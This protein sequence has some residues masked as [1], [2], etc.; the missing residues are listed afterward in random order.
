MKL[1]H[2]NKGNSYISP[3]RQQGPKP[4]QIP[5]KSILKWICGIALVLFLFLGIGIGCFQ[6]YH[7]ATTA[8]CFAIKDVSV[9]G[10]SQLSEQDILS[11]SGLHP[12]VNC[13]TVSIYD[14]ERN[15]Y[16]NPWVASVSVQR[17]LPSSFE[18][19]VT[20]HKPAF[21]LSRHMEGS[22]QASFSLAE[23]MRVSSESPG[24]VVCR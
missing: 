5:A 12:G 14:V 13:F 23:R 6:L 22:L 2:R 17:H 18:I 7:F 20:E 21:T 1:F 8:E 19:H 10:L 9:H 11:V 4:V 15:I 24:K 16:T 3:R